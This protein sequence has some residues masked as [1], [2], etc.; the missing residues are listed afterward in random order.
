M[1]I[2]SEFRSGSFANGPLDLGVTV[3]RVA[4][5]GAL[6]GLDHRALVAASS[7][8]IDAVVDNINEVGRANAMFMRPVS[9]FVLAKKNRVCIARQGSRKIG[10]RGEG[11]LTE[12]HP[13]WRQ[14]A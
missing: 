3:G 4:T 8:Q 11:L 2:A 6:D 9:V 1:S 12:H 14:S 13:A 7:L 10:S 5:H